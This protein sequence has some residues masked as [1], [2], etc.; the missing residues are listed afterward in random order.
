MKRIKYQKDVEGFIKEAETEIEYIE[1]DIRGSKWNPACFWSQQAAEKALKALWAFHGQKPI[2]I[3]RLETLIKGVLDKSP[4]LKKFVRSALF[5]DQF[6]LETRYP[7]FSGEE[8]IASKKI[9]EKALWLAR[10][11]VSAVKKELKGSSGS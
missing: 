7:D 8:I 11:I 9:G 4:V 1:W 3:H 6:Y 10:E 5:L 2:K